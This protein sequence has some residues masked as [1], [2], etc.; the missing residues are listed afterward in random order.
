VFSISLFSDV[1]WRRNREGQTRVFSISTVG[2]VAEPRFFDV[3][4]P[5]TV[6][7]LLHSAHLFLSPDHHIKVNYNCLRL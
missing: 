2:Y 5:V 4:Y 7:R 3:S 6:K 1:Y